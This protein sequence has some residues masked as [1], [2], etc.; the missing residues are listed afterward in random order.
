MRL[1]SAPLLLLSTMLAACSGAPQAVQPPNTQ[2]PDRSF[3]GS[4]PLY[5]PSVP[6]DITL[7][8]PDD[9]ESWFKATGASWLTAAGVA[10]QGQQDR[11]TD[12]QNEGEIRT[13]AAGRPE[14]A[15]A[16]LPGPDGDVPRVVPTAGGPRTILTLGRNLRLGVIASG[17]RRF[18]TAENQLGLYALTYG[19]LKTV[20]AGQHVAVSQ[21]GLPDPTAPSTRAMG[22]GQ[23]RALN[24]RVAGVAIQFQKQLLSSVFTLDAASSEVGAGDQLD[25]SQPGDCKPPSTL[26]IYNNLDWPLKPLTTSVKDQGNRGTCW[27]FADVAALEIGIAKRDHKLVNLSEQD[28][29]GH[30]M[31][32]LRP[33]ATDE[34]GDGGDIARGAFEQ[35]YEFAFENAY[36][37][38]KS[39]ARQPTSH[40]GLPWL[41][42]AHS[43]DGYSGVCSDTNYQGYFHCTWYLPPGSA[44]GGA[45][46]AR[47]MPSL[48]R[49]SGYRVGQSPSDFWEV[50][51]TDRSLVTLLLRSVLGNPTVIAT[52]DRYLTPDGSGYV[53][54]R[55]PMRVA[56]ASGKMVDDI[57]WGNHVV[58]ITGFVSNEQLASKVPSAPQADG[59]GYFIVK[60]SWGDC[61]GDVGYAYVPYEWVRKYVGEAFTGIQ[62]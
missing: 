53:P 55:A 21:F 25:R 30:R 3:Y 31:L 50:G 7:L 37:Y 36:Q 20:L 40:P 22:A 61:W 1:H 58:T 14:F 29:I 27:A 12:A 57:Q 8:S 62:P 26:G 46:C 38:N 56:D 23:L 32:D 24:D 18:P 4:A 48:A 5:G 52:D 2:P 39:P 54:D 34:G 43:C 47:S 44:Q 49:R 15:G 42:Y 51:N 59:V 9:F 60:N 28:L 16:L 13:L 33:R 19:D 17:L 10:G 45:V 6:A 41:Q 11:A 35:G